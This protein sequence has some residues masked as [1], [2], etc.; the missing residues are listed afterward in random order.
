V[1][2]GRSCWSC[3]S[4]TSTLLARPLRLVCPCARRAG[5]R[6]SRGRPARRSVE[7]PDGRPVELRQLASLPPSALADGEIVG[8][9]L[10]ITVADPRQDTSVYSDRARLRRDAPTRF[11]LDPSSGTLTGVRGD[12]A[13]RSVATSPGTGQLFELTEFKGVERTPLQTRCRPRIR[14]G[15]RSRC[16]VSTR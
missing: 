3:S 6:S 12:V 9:R 13:R 1:I 5:R 15:C 10:A 8:G 2:P 14:C 11:G 7:D 16:A 4:A